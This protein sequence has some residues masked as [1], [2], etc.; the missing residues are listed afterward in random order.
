MHLVSFSYILFLKYSPLRDFM[1]FT[2]CALL[3]GF[4]V[5]AAH[6]LDYLDKPATKALEFNYPLTIRPLVCV[7]V[8]PF[9]FIF[10][11]AFDT[12]FVA[13]T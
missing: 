3:D 2:N 5:R 7:A 6:W 11:V 10:R 4:A 9:C 1:Y 8:Q 12:S 13:K